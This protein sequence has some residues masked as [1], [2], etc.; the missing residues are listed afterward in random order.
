MVGWNQYFIN[1]AKE[2]ARKS[3]DP[4]SKVGCVLVTRDNRP[5]SFGYNGFVSGCDEQK[6]TFERPMKYHLI[7]HAEMNAMLFAEKSV[8]GGK[9]YVTHGP[10]E[11]CLKHL[12]QAGITE[13]YY[14][15]A[16][17][18]K[19][20]GTPEQKE[21]IGRLLSSKDVVC[22]NINGTEYFEEIT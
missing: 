16:G 11:N 12:L 6:M 19:E 13:I 18:L 17:I 20:R 5:I 21:A 22:K 7:I 14:E 2:V 4:S 8:K 15:N 10:C 1:I 3:K 9:A